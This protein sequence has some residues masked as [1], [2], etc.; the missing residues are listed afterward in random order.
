MF[1]EIVRA[2]KHL[3]ANKQLLLSIAKSKN[4]FSNYLSSVSNISF[5]RNG[6]IFY[7][8]NKVEHMLQLTVKLVAHIFTCI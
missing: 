2:Y 5:V 6:G 1:L 7:D 8:G 4:M 3:F